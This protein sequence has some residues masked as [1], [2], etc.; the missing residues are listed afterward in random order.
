M[1]RKAPRTRLA[2][3]VDR[4][5]FYEWA[6]GHLAEG[7]SDI[8]AIGEF[9]VARTLGC[10]PPSRKAQAL[11]DLVT[12]GGVTI[13]V[14]TTSKKSFPERA[15][16][17]YRWSVKDQAECLAG[18]RPLAEVWVFLAAE[19]PPE[20]AATA[21]FDV[22][23]PRYWTAYVARG[24]AVRSLGASHSV[25]EKGLARLGVAPVPLAELSLP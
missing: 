8:G 7:D 17:Y 2:A 3:L 13:E 20:A 15:G 14:K 24:E 9:M 21:R 10:L 11:Y 22:F 25:S 18:R 1:K 16:G 23:D 4:L 12:S 6:Y 19:F 5:S